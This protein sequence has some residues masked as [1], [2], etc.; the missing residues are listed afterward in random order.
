MVSYC[1]YDRSIIGPSLKKKRNRIRFR[2]RLTITAENKDE[3]VDVLIRFV[4]RADSYR[5][6]SCSKIFVDTKLVGDVRENGLIFD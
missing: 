1:A 3:V 4:G 6:A 2:K 5:S